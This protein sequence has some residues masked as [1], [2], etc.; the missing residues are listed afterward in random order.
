LRMSLRGGGRRLLLF[1][2]NAS[3][4]LVL[5]VW[6]LERLLQ[7]PPCPATSVPAQDLAPHIP[8]TNG[9]ADGAPRGGQIGDRGLSV[10]MTARAT[11]ADG[12]YSRTAS[13]AWNRVHS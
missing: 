2:H 12:L 1:P 9:S 6:L 13:S 11:S 7:R 5:C 3:S 8:S 10:E 4:A